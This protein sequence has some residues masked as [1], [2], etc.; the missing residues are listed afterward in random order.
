MIT[1]RRHEFITTLHE[2][3]I[4]IIVNDKID[5]QFEKIHCYSLIGYQ[6]NMYYFK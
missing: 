6:F 4:L 1:F 3:A 2:M 5:K